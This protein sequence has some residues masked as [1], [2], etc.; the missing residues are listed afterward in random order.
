VIP[1]V[2]RMNG[3]HVRNLSKM[4]EEKTLEGTDRAVRDLA[5]TTDHYDWR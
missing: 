3:V 1:T 2:E 5:E 4:T